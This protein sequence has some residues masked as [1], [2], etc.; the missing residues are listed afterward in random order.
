M[1]IRMDG[2]IHCNTPNGHH[3]RHH[4]TDTICRIVTNTVITRNRGEGAKSFQCSKK[5]GCA[6]GQKAS[7]HKATTKE[8]AAK[9]RVIKPPSQFLTT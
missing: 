4:H 8:L 7:K 1:I 5:S 3:S 2:D 9:L 6:I